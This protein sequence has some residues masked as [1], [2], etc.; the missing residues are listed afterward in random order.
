MYGPLLHTVIQ[1]QVKAAGHRD[2]YL[3]QISMCVSRSL[4][5]GW[6]VIQVVDPRDLKWNVL[7]VLNGT[8]VAPGIVHDWKIDPFGPLQWIRSVG[9]EKR[10]RADLMMRGGLHITLRVDSQW[11]RMTSSWMVGKTTK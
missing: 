4:R 9:G 1:V 7:E 5:H 8:Q 6:D 2:E 10:W 3:N 11:S